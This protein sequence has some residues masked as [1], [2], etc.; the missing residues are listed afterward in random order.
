MKNCLVKYTGAKAAEPGVHTSALPMP[1]K[2]ES[3]VR[4]KVLKE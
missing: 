4:R 1:Q 3:E 2:R